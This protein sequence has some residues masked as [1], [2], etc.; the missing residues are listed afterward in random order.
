MTS[1]VE[2]KQHAHQMLDQLEPGQLDAVVKLLEVMI[3]PIDNDAL[4][5]EDR[6]AVAASCEYFRQNP[7]GGVFSSRLSRNVV[8]PWTRS[9][10]TT[11]TS[12]RV[13][14]IRFRSNVPSEVRAIE[15]QTA[16]HILQCIHRDAGTGEG[17]VRSLSGEFEGLLRLRIG[18]YRVLFDE[19]ED[20]IT[21]QRVRDRREAYR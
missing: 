19:T 16:L 11:A 1:N 7:D 18:N 15:R 12:S 3:R 14:R 2:V 20:T 10:T 6:Q 17:D 5:E 8:S 4:T 21:G 13:K 9:A